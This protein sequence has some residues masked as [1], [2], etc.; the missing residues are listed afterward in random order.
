VTYDSN[1]KNRVNAKKHLTKLY[2]PDELEKIILLI[3]DYFGYC[4]PEIIL[5]TNEANF[6]SLAE[7]INNSIFGNQNIIKAKYLCELFNN[8]STSKKKSINKIEAIK[9][10]I[11][12]VL[13]NVPQIENF[14][15]DEKTISIF[16][17]IGIYQLDNNIEKGYTIKACI[18]S[19]FNT[20][21]FLGIGGKKWVEENTAINEMIKRLLLRRQSNQIRFLLLNPDCHEANNFNKGRNFSH[22]G[23]IDDLNITINYF[24]DLR[25]KSGLDIQLRLYSKMPNFRITI[26]D[27]S[28]VVMGT[29]STLSHNGL[30]SPQIIFKNSSNWSFAHNLI[31]YFEQLWEESLIK[32]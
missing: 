18:D 26:I 7:G 22:S 2:S 13:N 1:Y 30:D 28:T 12:E 4:F 10:Y 14:Q 6:E 24:T 27:Q 5:N 31:A 16:K 3:K 23:F 11:N 32:F 20:L 29:Y 17:K 8:T 9:K 15:P 21:S 25:E 19:V